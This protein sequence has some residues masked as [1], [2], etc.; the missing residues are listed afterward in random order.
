MSMFNIAILVFTLT[1]ILPCFSG[2]DLMK[3]DAQCTNKYPEQIKRKRKAVHTDDM[4]DGIFEI[5]LKRMNSDDS[6][7]IQFSPATISLSP[8]DLNNH[9]ESVSVENVLN[10]NADLKAVTTNM[11]VEEAR[12]EQV[13]LVIKSSL[14]KISAGVISNQSDFSAISDSPEVLNKMDED[15]LTMEELV[16]KLG[17]MRTDTSENLNDVNLDLDPEAEMED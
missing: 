12:V 9:V 10:K 4:V 2:E 7:L 14:V 16:K 11:L 15:D 3:I 6:N 17:S 5:Q 1:L 13:L 8:T